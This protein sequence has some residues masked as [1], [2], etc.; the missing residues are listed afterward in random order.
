MKKLSIN[1]LLIVF[2]I[3]PITGYADSQENELVTRKLPARVSPA[4][5]PDIP[6][7]IADGLIRLG[8]EIG[9]SVD[10]HVP[11]NVIE[12][13]FR[14]TG[15]KDIAVLC[16]NKLMSSI[17]VFWGGSSVDYDIL[18]VNKNNQGLTKWKGRDL[19]YVR[20]LSAVGKKQIMSFYEGFGGPKPPLIDHQG[21]DDYISG[22]ASR[23][24]Y[25]H[26]GKWLIL[27]GM[28]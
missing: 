16:A 3:L 19:G 7:I 6:E 11:H 10:R 12:G 4:D 20:L 5:Y 13:E 17:V 18:A 23:I 14:K 15:T 28:D 8:C 9:Q 24:Y 25:Y 1:I 26:E 22:K 21:I 2:I 27:Q